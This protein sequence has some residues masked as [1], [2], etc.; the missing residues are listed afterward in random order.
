[1]STQAEV[2]TGSGGRLCSVPPTQL[3]TDLS[4]GPAHTSGM[5]DSQPHP[6]LSSRPHGVSDTSG[7]IVTLPVC[8]PV[9]K[10]RVQTSSNEEK[11]KSR[12]LLKMG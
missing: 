2:P 5:H 10:L 3:S 12:W 6:G 11:V 9:G 8:D 1:M 7:R 4:L